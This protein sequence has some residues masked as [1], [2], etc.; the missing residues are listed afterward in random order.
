MGI[1]KLPVTNFTIVGM[2]GILSG[3]FHAPLTA[4]FLIG[5][6]T[7]GYGLMIPLMIV[8]SISFAISKRLETH[9]MDVKALADKGEVFTSD[10]DKNILLSIDA[11]N[12]IQTHCETV[13]E[14]T[15]MEKLVGLLSSRKQP[16]YPVLNDKQQLVGIIEFD[17]IRAVVFNSFQVKYSTVKEHMSYPEYTLHYDEDI[18]SMMEKFD[19]SDKEILPVLKNGKFYGYLSKLE[20]LEAYRVKFREMVIE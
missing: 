15:S 4:I 3:L 6:I 2:A 10:K 17:K 11:L 18:N 12:L 14:D 20:L 19:T 9:S 13:T 16:L 1:T 7:G 8:S 5:E